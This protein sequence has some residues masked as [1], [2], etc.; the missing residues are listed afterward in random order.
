MPIG[1]SGVG[2]VVSHSLKSGWGLLIRSR[3]FSNSLSHFTN[4]WQFWSISHWPLAIA[5]SRS[6]N[7]NCKTN[8][9]TGSKAWCWVFCFCSHTKGIDEGKSVC[10]DLSDSSRST[11]KVCTTLLGLR[12]S[13]LSP[14]SPA[15]SVG[16]AE[17]QTN[18]QTNNQEKETENRQ[19]P[20][21]WVC[22]SGKGMSVSG[23][24]EIRLQKCPLG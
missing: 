15:V 10:F 5:V 2:S 13:T 24:R 21:H 4:K 12:M 7:A 1:N 14:L 11:S 23:E 8:N 17:R 20:T 6:C 18:K 3:T 19:G 16:L 9:K 22:V